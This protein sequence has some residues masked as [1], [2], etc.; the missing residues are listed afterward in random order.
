MLLMYSYSNWSERFLHATLPMMKGGKGFLLL[1]RYF[2]VD[3]VKM[4]KAKFEWNRNVRYSFS[5]KASANNLI[6]NDSLLVNSFGAIYFSELKNNFLD[7]AYSKMEWPKRYKHDWFRKVDLVASHKWS[8]FYDLQI[9]F[10]LTG[11]I[12]TVDSFNYSDDRQTDDESAVKQ[13]GH[14]SQL[15]SC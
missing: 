3:L 5:L 1:S 9:V 6:E 8:F 14:N 12:S 2:W 4:F 11:H 13:L 15:I 10:Y 7:G